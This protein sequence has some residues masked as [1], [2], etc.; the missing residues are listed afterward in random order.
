MLKFKETTQNYPLIT[1]LLTSTSISR[2]IPHFPHH[3]KS[4]FF[5]RLF[6]PQSYAG[7]PFGGKDKTSF[8]KQT[9]HQA[10]TKILRK[11]LGYS[12]DFLPEILAFY[13]LAYYSAIEKV[14]TT[15]PIRDVTKA[16]SNFMKQKYRSKEPCSTQINTIIRFK[17]ERFKI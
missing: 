12:T 7:L 16:L 14:S 3:G 5:S 15:H 8:T 10:S 1:N 11:I 9:Q 6:P 2:F 17:T 13:N 4:R